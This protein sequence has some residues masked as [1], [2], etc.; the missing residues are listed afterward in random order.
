M[1]A[2]LP[3]TKRRTQ[4]IYLRLT[5]EEKKRIERA[6]HAAS[7]KLAPWVLQAVT[8]ACDRQEK[9]ARAT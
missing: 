2:P 1:A 6:A 8:A 4:Y 7:S 9:T 5:S 3:P